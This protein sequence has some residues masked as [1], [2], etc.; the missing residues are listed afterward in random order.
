M[1][2]KNNKLRLKALG[3]E[4]AGKTNL[5]KKEYTFRI[6]GDSPFTSAIKRRCEQLGVPYTTSYAFT[7]FGPAIYD[8]EVVEDEN[9]IEL[10]DDVDAWFDTSC[11][12]EAVYRILKAT[13]YTRHNVLIV[14]RGP[15]VRGLWNKLITE[16]DNTVT[17]I[18]SK[19]N[20]RFTQSC[21]ADVLIWAAP[22]ASISKVKIDYKLVIDLTGNLNTSLNKGFHV[23][24]DFIDASD[25]GKITTA[26]AVYRAADWGHLA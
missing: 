22:N 2:N 20:L 11:C 19:T 17:V 21:A 9:P 10:S 7:A 24:D 18:H 16:T 3:W 6:L 26:V 14:G 12:A 25:V 1:C 8:R 5:A 13:E 23:E 15:A 4:Y